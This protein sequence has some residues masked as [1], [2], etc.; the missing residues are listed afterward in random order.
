MRSNDTCAAQTAACCKEWQEKK[1][2]IYPHFSN[3]DCVDLLSTIINKSL[4]ENDE[5]VPE[6]MIKL[7]QEKF[8]LTHSCGIIAFEPIDVMNM[9]SAETETR[10]RI[11]M[12]SSD[13]IYIWVSNDK[14][15]CSLPLVTSDTV[16]SDTVSDLT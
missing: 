13:D 16:T 1:D 9:I 7:L 10:M 14:I 15:E 3:N 12:S 8:G 4:T 2:T 5:D 11:I 6:L